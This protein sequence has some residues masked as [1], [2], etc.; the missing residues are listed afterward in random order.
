MRGERNPNLLNRSAPKISFSLLRVSLRNSLNRTMPAI[1]P[2]RS[3][4]SETLRKFSFHKS[5]MILPVAMLANIA[6]INTLAK[7][8]IYNNTCLKFTLLSCAL[9]FEL[10]TLQLKVHFLPIFGTACARS[11]S[12]RTEFTSPSSSRKLLDLKLQAAA[13]MLE[14]PTMKHTARHNPKRKWPNCELSSF[15]GLRHIPIM[16]AQTESRHLDHLPSL[17][18]RSPTVRFQNWRQIG[19]KNSL[20]LR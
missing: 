19:R 4:I 13:A 3:L 11:L 7:V 14:N 18:P 6:R 17:Y 15:L 12:E 1:L 8:V 5:D 20:G 10:W 9:Y 16:V 2:S